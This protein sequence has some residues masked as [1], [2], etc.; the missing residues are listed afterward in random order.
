VLIVMAGLPGTGKSTLAAALA[1]E[2]GAA[3]PDKD[4]VRAAL[5]PPPVLDCSAA[6]NDLSMAAVYQAAALIL[7]TEP[8]RAVILDGRPFVR[9]GQV[10][11][12]LAFA[13]S[14]GETPR[15]IECVCD[16]ATARRRLERDHD[17]GGHPAA[18]RS[19]G[20]LLT[21]GRPGDCGA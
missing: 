8:G 5:F 18:D 15:V 20:L 3:V 6:Q 17:R 16:E 14:V 13:V 2:L 21:A 1:R 19:S 10:D 11:G 7:R 12:L 4:A 9:P